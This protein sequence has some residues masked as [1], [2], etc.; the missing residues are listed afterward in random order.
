MWLDKKR[1][2]TYFFFIF[3]EL[4][5]KTHSEMALVFG[6]TMTN[7]G[8]CQLKQRYTQTKCPFPLER[9][10]G[11][12]ITPSDR[13]NKSTSLCALTCPDSKIGIFLAHRQIWQKIATQCLPGLILEEDVRFSKDF[14]KRLNDEALP[15]LKTKELVLLGNFIV[16]QPKAKIPVVQRCF[17]A[18]STG[19]RKFPEG[20]S[21]YTPTWVFGSHGYLLTPASAQKLLNLFP[22]VN[23]HVDRALWIAIRN[24]HLTSV[25]LR[26][27][28]VWQADFAKSSQITPSAKKFM[29]ATD[30][31]RGNQPDMVDFQWAF[32]V[33]Q[34]RVG[35]RVTLNS[36]DIILC[37]AAL[38]LV[39]LLIIKKRSV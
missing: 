22:L 26:P 18:L 38:C 30:S 34:L 10:Q 3:S 33:H 31:S 27:S 32:G 16:G 2:F 14:T 17:L 24:K 11:V 12:T 28:L 36:Q 9:I 15:W 7:K 37:V 5:K 19:G 4:V 6:I 39:L 21:S 35:S 13:T 23:R 20:Q 29:K 8:F 1:R 25:A